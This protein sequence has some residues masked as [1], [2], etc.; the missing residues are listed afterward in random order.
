MENIKNSC[1]NNDLRIQLQHE[2]IDLNYLMDHID[3]FLTTK[4][5]K[6]LGS[7]E[8]QVIKHK[9]SESLAHLE[10]MEVI[11]VRCSCSVVN[12]THQ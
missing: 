1:K 9:N 3:E 11:L 10:I 2:I 8:N 6:L 12:N 7:T 5:M 4:M